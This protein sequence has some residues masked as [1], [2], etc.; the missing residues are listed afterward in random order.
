MRIT[1]NASGRRAH[2]LTS[3]NIDVIQRMIPT[4][5]E[6][7]P[8]TRQISGKPCACSCRTQNHT[9]RHKRHSSA[10]AVS[11]SGN[12]GT[13]DNNSPRGP[14]TTRILFSEMRSRATIAPAAAPTSLE[15]PVDLNIR[16]FPSL[17]ERLYSAMDFQKPKYPRKRMKNRAREVC[18]RLEYSRWRSAMIGSAI[19]SNP[20]C[21]KYFSANLRSLEPGNFSAFSLL[22]IG[23]SPM[24]ISVPSASRYPA[25]VNQKV[26]VGTSAEAQ[27]P[28][29][30]RTFRALIG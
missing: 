19:L 29:D 15:K 13:I 7:F 24:Q 23:Q 17:L 2:S 26:W 10:R 5:T 27:D 3:R 9:T 22:V 14:L 28:S 30:Q 11:K 21:S 1:L 6:I 18:S 25:P 16:I 4:G 8:E 20:G 12:R